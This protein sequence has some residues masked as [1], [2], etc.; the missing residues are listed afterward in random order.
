[1]AWRI[2]GGLSGW[3]VSLAPIVAVNVLAFTGV[4]SPN[5]VAI[6]GGLALLL[7][8]ALGSWLAGALGGRS[9]P[10]LGGVVAGVIT[11][12]LFSGTLI[13]VM[14]LLRAQ[15]QLPYLLALH[16]IRTTG[17][18]GFVACL[19]LCV[20]AVS[21]AASSRRAERR[22]V[23]QMAAA[24]RAYGVASQPRARQPEGS[25]PMRDPRRVSEPRMSERAPRR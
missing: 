3:L 10:G 18:I 22:A 6:A 5:D 8:I 16:P 7:G 1:M 24:Q 9:G 14:Y 13:G 2:L 12:A 17:A 21:G 25:R 19:I 4:I 20:A 23:E 15:H 11:A